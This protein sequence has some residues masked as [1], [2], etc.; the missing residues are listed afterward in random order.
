MISLRRALEPEYVW[1]PRQALRR[2][3]LDWRP[4]EDSMIA[5]LPWG[6]ALHVS[7]HDAIGQR[8]LARGLYDLTVS[9]TL[10]RL[11]EVGQHC[12]DVGANIGPHTAVMA[13]RLGGEGSVWAFE[14]HPMLFPRLES[15]LRSWRVHLPGLEL[16]GFSTALAER[17][18]FGTASLD[19]LIDGGCDVVRIEA[20]RALL[21]ILRGGARCLRQGRIRDFVFRDPDGPDSSASALLRE[22]GYSVYRLARTFSGPRLRHGSFA[23]DERGGDAPAYLATRAPGRATA[24]MEPRGWR[25]LRP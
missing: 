18:G 25:A 2:L 14:P 4:R 10:W 5:R 22:H 9:E 23:L 20:G 19:D 1:R 21:S 13:A 16:R 11:I 6:L 17:S 24:L 8:V 15:H 3:F 12:L 7:Q